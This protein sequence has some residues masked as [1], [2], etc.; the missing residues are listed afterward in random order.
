MSLAGWHALDIFF[1]LLGCYFVIRGCFR[2]FVGEILTFAGFLCALYVSFRFSDSLGG[3]LGRTTGLNEAVAQVLAIIL[4]WLAVS[5]I[6][7]VLRRILRTIVSAVSLGGIDRIFG[8]FC[9][10]AKTVLVVYVVLIGGLLLA[11][12]VEPTW[13]SHSDALKFAGRKWPE[14]RQFLL[15]LGVLPEGT[16]LPDGTLEQILRPYRDGNARPRGLDTLDTL[17]Q[18][19]QIPSLPSAPAPQSETL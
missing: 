5:L 12:V 17:R 3:L 6:V 15:D 8:I 2:G 9:G 1:V 19:P 7:A 11:P 14:A 13:M 10:L 18:L 16:E 4:V